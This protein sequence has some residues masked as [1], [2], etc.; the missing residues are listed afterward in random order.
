[1]WCSYHCVLTCCALCAKNP[2]DLDLVKYL[3]PWYVRRVMHFVHM[4]SSCAGLCVFLSFWNIYFYHFFRFV[5]CWFGCVYFCCIFVVFTV[6]AVVSTFEWTLVSDVSFLL[7]TLEYVILYCVTPCLGVLMIVGCGG[8]AVAL[9][10]VCD[11]RMNMFVV[12]SPQLKSGIFLGAFW[13]MW[14]ISAATWRR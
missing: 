4:Y 13:R 1:M 6:D 8:G 9:L 11:I 10:S 14:C 3:R 12:L 2:W 7:Y 5:I